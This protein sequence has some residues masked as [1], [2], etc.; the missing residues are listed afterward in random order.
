M[1]IA[2]NALKKVWRISI[3]ISIYLYVYIDKMLTMI[4]SE[5]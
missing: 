2:R 3:S 1:F 4:I 5:S